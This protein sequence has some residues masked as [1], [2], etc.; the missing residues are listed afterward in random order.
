MRAA[1]AARSQSARWRASPRSPQP[2]RAGAEGARGGA[3]AR[4]HAVERSPALARTPLVARWS[5]SPLEPELNRRRARPRRR[6]ARAAAS[7]RR[8]VSDCGQRLG[9]L[10]RLLRTAVEIRQW[11]LGSPR[12]RLVRKR[13]PR[14]PH[15]DTPYRHA[16]GGRGAPAPNGPAGSPHAARHQPACRA[17]SR[18]R[19]GGRVGRAPSCRR[20]PVCRASSRSHRGGPV[21][22]RPYG[23]RRWSFAGR[24][25]GKQHDHPKGAET[26]R[27]KHGETRP[28]RRPRA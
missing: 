10:N 2:G 25:H 7:A 8:H 28:P 27:A 4:A 17:L 11:M 22:L 20:R 1:Q 13:S 5:R 14:N 21:D 15:P 24:A 9:R 12:R 16:W 6:P 26:N 3:D 18:P 19:R 23:G